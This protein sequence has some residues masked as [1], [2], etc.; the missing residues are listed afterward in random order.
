MKDGEIWRRFVGGGCG[1]GI[2][3][4]VKQGGDEAVRVMRATAGRGVVGS[5][6]VWIP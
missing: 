5:E 2:S 1:D 4:G 6:G 3:R